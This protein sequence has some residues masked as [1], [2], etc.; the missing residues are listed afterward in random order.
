MVRNELLHTSYSYS[1]FHLTLALAT[2]FT[3]T[4]LTRWFQPREYGIADLDK[5]WPIVAVKVM[6]AWSCGLV[7][8]L[9]M[10]LPS[11]CCCANEDNLRDTR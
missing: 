3:A 4:Q 6:V 2:M 7:Y 10:L 11:N 5:S 1:F 9:Y 8:F